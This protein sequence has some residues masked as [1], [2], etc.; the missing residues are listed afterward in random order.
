MTYQNLKK[1]DVC[2]GINNCIG[3]RIV[4]DFCEKNRVTT[5]RLAGIKVNVYKP[6]NP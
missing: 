6:K 1:V 3:K 5:R 2:P 4:C